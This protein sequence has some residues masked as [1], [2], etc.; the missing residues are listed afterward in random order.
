MHSVSLPLAERRFECAT[1]MAGTF[2]LAE[3]GLPASEFVKRLA[4]GAVETPHGVLAFPA[5]E[6]STPPRHGIHYTPYNPAGNQA[7]LDTLDI[8]GAQTA[9]FL[10]QPHL[11]W[12]L[13]G[14]NPPYN[15][16]GDILW[17][18]K[19]P[20]ISPAITIQLVAQCGV[21]ID[22]ASNLQGEAATLRLALAR[23]LDPKLAAAG[24]LVQI[25]GRVERLRFGITELQ[26][27]QEESRQIGEI[28]FSV[29]VGAVL[30]CFA[31]YDGLA[32]HRYWLTDPA[33]SQNPRREVF[34]S[35]GGGIKAITDGL[36]ETQIDRGA[37]RRFESAVS[38]LLWVLGFSPAHLGDIPAMQDA[39]DIVV[40]TPLGHIALV[41]CT[42]GMVKQDKLLTLRARAAAVRQ[43]LDAVK[44]GTFRVLAVLVC[45]RPDSEVEPE[46][47]AAAQ[48]GVA[49][50]SMADFDDLLQRASWMPDSERVYAD[51]E[52]AIAQRIAALGSG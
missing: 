33:R 48:M 44:L 27:T 9:V 29:P 11:D 20:P 49:V 30:H 1:A 18:F 28:S 26:W 37:A 3:A 32:H 21:M 13:R 40:A 4:D 39:P 46:R 35:L 24:V 25:Q 34:D 2:A 22:A 5:N 6:G 36:A 8:M 14:A 52:S 15:G 43:K 38:W 50:L 10:R 31:S 17:D 45:A 19:L 7:R 16:V 47:D 51:A 42:T 41:E 12:S 23:G